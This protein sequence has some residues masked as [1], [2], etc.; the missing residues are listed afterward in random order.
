MPY[1]YK[2]DEEDEKKTSKAY[3]KEVNMSFKKAN[4]VCHVIKG[5]NVD[6]AIAYLEKVIKKEAFVPFRRYKTKIGHKTGGKPG[7]YPAKVA[8]KVIELLKNAKANAGYKGLNDE[9][10]KIEHATANKALEFPRVKPKG[11]RGSPRPHN[12]ELTN[13]EI[14][15]REY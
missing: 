8:K 10:L 4:E 2:L 7:K 13:V 5:M 9:R 6:S 15:L 12:M 1:S 3:G 14:I 11:G